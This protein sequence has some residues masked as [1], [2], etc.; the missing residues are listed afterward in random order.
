MA[1]RSQESDMFSVHKNRLMMVFYTRGDNQSKTSMKKYFCSTFRT[2]VTGKSI[3][4]DK[5]NVCLGY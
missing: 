5:S 4:E 2:V 3:N 1:Y